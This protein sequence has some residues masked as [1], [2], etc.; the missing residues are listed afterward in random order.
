MSSLSAP[1]F[2]APGRRD[3]PDFERLIA[4]GRTEV[5]RWSTQQRERT[6][7]DGHWYIAAMRVAGQL[8]VQS[9]HG[10]DARELAQSLAFFARFASEAELLEHSA[11]FPS[12]PPVAGNE[13]VP[14][15]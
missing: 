8:R 4:E 3:S 9:A 11:D 12:D 6:G 7:G 14:G 1:V 2:P 13:R 5:A 10:P 15:Q